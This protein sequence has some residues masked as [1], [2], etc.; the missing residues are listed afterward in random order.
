M[1]WDET[2]KYCL[3]KPGAFLAHPFGPDSDIVKV[4]S[5]NGPSR[6]FAQFFIL[7]GEEKATLNCDSMRGDFYRGL[8]PGIVT[9]GYHCPPVQ[10]PYF[11]TLPL[12]GAIPDNVLFLMI[13]EAYTAWFQKCR[14]S[15]KGSLI[16]IREAE[17]QGGAGCL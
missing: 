7:N 15:I 12:N 8:Y 11:N 4:K 17:R 16:I 1:T 5:K 10:Q 6:I 2:L 3:S 13:D 14:R 9:R